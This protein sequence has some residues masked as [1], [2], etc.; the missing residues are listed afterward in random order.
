MP[1]LHSVAAGGILT[2]VGLGVAFALGGTDSSPVEAPATYS[3]ATTDITA[4]EDRRVRVIPMTDAAA[5]SDSTP[6]YTRTHSAVPPQS[7]K[8]RLVPPE[9]KESVRIVEKSRKITKRVKDKSSREVADHRSREADPRERDPY[10]A[11]AFVPE[12]RNFG[13]NLFR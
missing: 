7:P 12:Q 10:S 6:W 9:T 13:F 1:S 3:A 5:S 8:T 11:R 4:A 2:V